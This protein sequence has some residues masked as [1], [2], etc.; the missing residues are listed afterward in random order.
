MIE[1]PA[2]SGTRISNPPSLPASP[3]FLYSIEF[4]LLCSCSMGSCSIKMHS[5]VDHSIQSTSTHLIPQITPIS[6]KLL[7]FSLGLK[8]TIIQQQTM[9]VPIFIW[10]SFLFA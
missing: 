5:L 3:L 8:L 1:W 9:P 10:D 2:I 6:K 7:Q 4:I